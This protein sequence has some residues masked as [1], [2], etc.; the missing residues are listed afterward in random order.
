MDRWNPDISFVLGLAII[1][2][3]SVAAVMLLVGG[4][5]FGAGLATYLVCLALGAWVT[6][7]ALRAEMQAMS[8]AR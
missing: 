3:G 1:L 7:V 8:G 5:R 2:I 4:G 6:G